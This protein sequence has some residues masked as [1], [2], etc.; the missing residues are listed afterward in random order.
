MSDYPKDLKTVYK[1]LKSVEERAK[2][3][4]W[5]RKR[6]WKR[7]THVWYEYDL[8]VVDLHDLNTKLAKDTLSRFVDAAEDFDTGAICFV[9]G[10]GKHSAG[11]FS[12]NRE[13]VIKS[14]QKLARKKENWSIYSQGNGR[15]VLV[16]N[17]EAAPKSAT[18]KL[19]PTLKA[20][21]AIFIFLLLMSSLQHCW[22]K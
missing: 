13:M 19:D 10:I 1:I 2:A 18:G 21:I 3:L 22:P 12:K 11:G 17:K 16:F 8:L 5:A 4:P 9:T 7:G 14:L 6:P 15:I 20:G